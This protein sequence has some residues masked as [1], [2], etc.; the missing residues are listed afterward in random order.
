MPLLVIPLGAVQPISM[1]AVCYMDRIRSV[2]VTKIVTIMET[3]VATLTALDV[4]DVS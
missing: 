3:V 4:F 1:T 2:S